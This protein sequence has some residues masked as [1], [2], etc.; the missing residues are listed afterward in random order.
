MHQILLNTVKVSLYDITTHKHIPGF[1][2]T[3]YSDLTTISYS[4]FKVADCSTY[5]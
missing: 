5:I 3:A 2:T 1:T 4:L